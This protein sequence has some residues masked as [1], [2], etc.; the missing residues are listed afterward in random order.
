MKS[1]K[2]FVLDRN[3]CGIHE[4][5]PSRKEGGTVDEPEFDVVDIEVAKIV[6]AVKDRIVV[7]LTEVQHVLAESFDEEAREDEQEVDLYEGQ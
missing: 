5:S 4:C 7:W 1:V 6:V 3:R 2:H